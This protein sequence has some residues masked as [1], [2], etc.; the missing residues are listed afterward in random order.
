MEEEIKQL[1]QEIED[2]SDR[3]IRCQQLLG[4]LQAAPDVIQTFD[5]K[6]WVALVDEAV[7]PA[8]GSR[9]IEFRMRGE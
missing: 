7:V 1:R 4:N 8:D 3:R 5:E 6:L 2:K 9:R